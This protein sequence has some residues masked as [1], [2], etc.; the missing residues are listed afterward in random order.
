MG[1]ARSVES[2]LH[3]H[4]VAYDL[5]PHPHTASSKE[6]A[7]VSHVPLPQMAK[8]VVLGDDRGFLLMA[9]IPAD[10]YVDIKTLSRRLGRDLHLIPEERLAPVFRDCEPG[11]IPPLGPVYGMET[12]LD[13]KLVGLPVVYFEAG[14]HEE[15]VR[16]DG[17]QFVQLL[18]EARH[19]D[20]SH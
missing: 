6:T 13:N 16:V 14:D 2:H 8:A 17:E 9:V 7:K 4:R 10:R 5:I 12:I 3:K 20:I 15:L 18:K 11:A 1:I 19:G